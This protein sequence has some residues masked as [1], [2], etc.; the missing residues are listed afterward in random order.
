M[1]ICG[2]ALMATIFTIIYGGG[3]KRPYLSPVRLPVNRH[4]YYYSRQ[5][6]KDKLELL[7]GSMV[8]G[9]IALM[10]TIFT[11]IYGGTGKRAYLLASITKT[12]NIQRFFTA[13]KMTNFSSFFFNYFRIFYYFRIFAQNIYCG[14]TLEPPH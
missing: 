5:S 14:Y 3:G 7:V 8:T 9:G 1:V 2:I 10:V 12:C 6:H 4:I 13:V 11:I